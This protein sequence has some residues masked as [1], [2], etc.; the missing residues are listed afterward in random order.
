MMLI[1]FRVLP[2][3]I[4]NLEFLERMDSNHVGYI[5]FVVSSAST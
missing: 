4:A 3:P 1:A 5:K 2:R